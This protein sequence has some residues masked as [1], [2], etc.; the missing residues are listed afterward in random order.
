MAQTDTTLSGKTGAAEAAPLLFTYSR[1][2][3]PWFRRSLIRAVERLSGR[4]RLERLYRSWVVARS[5]NETIFA[6]GLRLLDVAAEVSAPEIARI[7]HRG[8]LLVLVNHPFGIIDGLVVGDLLHRLRGDVK[9]LTHSLLC[10][11][12][13]AAEVLLPVDFSPGPEARRISLDTRRRAQE[14]LAAGHVVV[15]FPAGSVSTSVRPWAGPAVDA[16]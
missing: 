11:P 3:Q 2:D 10:Q 15:V 4:A 13:E 8:G 9:I 12:P 7:P 6:A 16:A 5:G 14:W 1:D